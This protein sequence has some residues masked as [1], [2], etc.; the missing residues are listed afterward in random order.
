M[1]VTLYNYISMEESDRVDISSSDGTSV[2]TTKDNMI[3]STV[4]KLYD[5]CGVSLKGLKI[6]QENNIPMTRGLGSSSACIV[7]GLIGANALLSNP[8]SLSDLV[9]LASEIE[10]HPDN[11]SP[12]MLGGL[13]T[14]VLEGDKVYWVKQEILGD[15]I[16]LVAVIPDFKLSTAMARQCLPQNVSHKD[17]RFNL[18]RAALFQAS[19]TSKNYQN[20]KVAVDDRLHQPY[21]SKLIK[22][23]D[24]VFKTAYGLGA[25][26][27]YISGAG[28]TIMS[29]IDA[30]ADNFADN[31]RKDLDSFGF[32]GWQIKE[33]SVDNTGAVIC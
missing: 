24:D 4:Q 11:T 28:P 14:S 15:D 21:R 19:L 12:A 3:Y 27:V 9:N 30:K 16:K 6:V 29:I 5:I 26:G 2:P 32:T 20:I 8:L 17:A 33:L 25:Y 18:S 13:V 7:G 23:C 22:G 1:A 31:L 10:G